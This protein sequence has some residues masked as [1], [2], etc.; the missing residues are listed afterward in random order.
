M[1]LYID[2][3]ISSLDNNHI[4]TVF[5]LIDELVLRKGNYKQ[6]FISTHSLEFLRYLRHLSVK[7]GEKINYYLIERKVRGSDSDHTSNLTKMPYHLEEY[8]TEFNHLF[9]EI[10]RF[11]L[12][13]ERSE[14][15]YKHRIFYTYTSHYNLA[16][17]IRKFLEI[18]LFYKYPNESSLIKKMERL[19]ED[20]LPSFMNRIINEYSHLT[21][22][23]RGYIPVQFE[24]LKDCVEVLLT[25]MEQEDSSQYEDLVRSVGRS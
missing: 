24:E 22:L 18:Y 5:S 13:I 23:E 15:G 9:S 12:N 20:P 21:V 25:T 11:H 7:E 16:N 2:D 3:P 10:Y 8:T 14:E 6:L 1:I 4:F 19:F 17:N